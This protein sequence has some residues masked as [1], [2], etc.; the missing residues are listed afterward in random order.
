MCASTVEKTMP[1]YEIFI[2]DDRYSVPSLYL[3][4]ATDSARARAIAERLW[5]DSKHH[6]GVELRRD[7]EL[8]FGCGTFEHRS[9]TGEERRSA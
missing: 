4:T 6:R 1:S 8:V 5:Q 9:G 2:D 7:G 3:I